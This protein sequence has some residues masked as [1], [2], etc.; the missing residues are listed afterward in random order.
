MSTNFEARSV[1][2]IGIG[3]H[4]QSSEGKQILEATS[5]SVP[6]TSLEMVNQWL[7]IPQHTS[8]LKCSK[9][10]KNEFYVRNNKEHGKSASIY[11]IFSCKSFPSKGSFQQLL[12]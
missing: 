5:L 8:L 2:N 6:N 7:K 9:S 10:N 11:G 1:E 4:K 12:C 3:E